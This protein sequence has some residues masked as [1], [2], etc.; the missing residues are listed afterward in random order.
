MQKCNKDNHTIRSL[1]TVFDKTILFSIHYYK[2]QNHILRLLCHMEFYM[3]KYN[4]V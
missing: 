2:I 4:A 3:I 1:H